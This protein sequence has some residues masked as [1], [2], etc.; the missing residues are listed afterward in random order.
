M[1]DGKLV[2]PTTKPRLTDEQKLG[3]VVWAQQ[4]LNMI[5]SG[6]QEL[7][8]CFL[9]EKLF[10]TTS[11]RKKYKILPK[12]SFETKEEAHLSMPKLRSC[13]YA[14]K[15]MYMGIVGNH[16][17]GKFDGKIYLQRVSEPY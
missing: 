8:Y 12:A 17:E 16:V 13:R 10:Y 2:A 5:E 9:D 6:G 11:C 1:N 7:H 15:V 14:L 3:R 4:L